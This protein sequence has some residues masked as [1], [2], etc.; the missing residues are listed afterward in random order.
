MGELD[1]IYQSL[2]MYSTKK[3][4]T[5]SNSLRRALEVNELLLNYQFDSG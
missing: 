3:N 2:K 4:Q 5:N 1:L